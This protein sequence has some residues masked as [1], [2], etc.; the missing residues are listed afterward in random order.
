MNPQN[1][2]CYTGPFINYVEIQEF[3]ESF[4]HLVEETTQTMFDNLVY[5]GKADLN[6]LSIDLTDE[7]LY[8]PLEYKIQSEFAVNASPL[9]TIP[10]E[11]KTNFVA[12]AAS[13]AT[14]SGKVKKRRR[15]FLDWKEQM[16][17]QLSLR[18]EDP[19][20]VIKKCTKAPSKAKPY[21]K[22]T[23]TFDFK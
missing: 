17:N 13:T 19:D 8:Q 11:T 6:S 5:D 20:F 2:F 15:H 1:T 22:Y 18:S 23:Q 10:T 7:S 3:L 14:F 4:E 21:E 9:L 16:T 12:P